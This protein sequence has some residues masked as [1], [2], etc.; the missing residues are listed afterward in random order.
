MYVKTQKFFILG[1]SKSGYAVAKRILENGGV[2]YIY[3]QLKNQKIERSIEELTS[4]GAVL[5][6][7][8]ETENIL[9]LCDVLVISPGVPIN[10][11]LAV[12][13]KKL[14]KRIIGEL[15]FGVL[16]FSPTLIAV[17]GTN[18][19]TTTV[20]MIDAILKDSGL[21]CF[22]VGN[23]GVPIS[24]KLADIDKES[25]C[26]T[27]VS[28]FQ[29]E[30]VF[31]FCPHISCILN[32]TPDHLERHYTMENY[33]YL[34][35]RIFKNQRESEYCVLNFDDQT[36]KSFYSE[37]K[38]KI[39]WV[40][41][42]EKVDGAY[43]LNGKLY[44]NG[45]YI[46]DEK[47]L[48]IKGEHNVMDALFSIAVAKLMKVSNEIIFSSLKNFKGV[49]HRIE[50][51]C[52]KKGVKFY[53]DSKATNTASTISAVNAFNVPTVL[54]LGGSEKGETYEELFAKIKES[55]VKH[56]VLTGASRYNM[57]EAAGKI[58]YSKL[59][60]TPDF[61]HAVQIAYLLS[62]KGDVVLLSPACASFDNFNGYEER[63]DCF[64]QEVGL[65]NE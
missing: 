4:L 10:H 36:V 11:E 47:D 22:L 16:Q 50:Y 15:E 8:T 49:R 29:L 25:V 40:S 54:I 24:A 61:N 41:L 32:I 39:I 12:T 30:S 55:T 37:I 21:N 51:I 1:V 35:K 48:S 42:K 34:K 65:L 13:A 17:T 5:V 62:E 45:E 14:G 53:N 33:I 27:E 63:G 28:S 58:G 19:K 52:E 56:V 46:I 7:D 6:K 26:V 3:E 57:L 23:V 9:N 60:L 20:S 31:S 43:L 64:V 2:C 18:G 38:A 44:F 59:T